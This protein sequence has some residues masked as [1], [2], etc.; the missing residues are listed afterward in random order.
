MQLAAAQVLLCKG[1]SSA[2]RPAGTRKPSSKRH[3]LFCAAPT[4]H[5]DD[6]LGQSPP[7]AAFSFVAPVA[8]MH[9]A[10]LTLST[11]QL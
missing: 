7:T 5:G 3:A 4:Q 11:Q 2:Y 10:A 1:G 8:M 6:D 9:S